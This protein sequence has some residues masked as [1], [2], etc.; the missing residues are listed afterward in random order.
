VKRRPSAFVLLVASFALAIAVS[1]LL[2][3]LSLVAHREIAAA[4]QERN[5]AAEELLEMEKLRAEFALLSTAHR[6]YL[7]SGEQEFVERATIHHATFVQLIKAL[8]PRAGSDDERRLIAEIA[9]QEAVHESAVVQ[10]ISLKSRGDSR[11]VTQEFLEHVLPTRDATQRAIGDLASERS[12]ALGA[13]ERAT[14]SAAART[15]FGFVGLSSLAILGLLLVAAVVIRA[16]WRERRMTEAWTMFLSVASHDLKSPLSALHLR[17]QVLEHLLAKG[18]VDD[19]RWRDELRRMRAQTERMAALVESVLDLT[20]LRLGTVALRPEEVDLSA[21]LTDAVER[22]RPEFDQANIELKL[23]VPGPV[24]GT[25]DPLRLDQVATNL[26]SNALKYGEQRPVEVRIEEADTAVRFAVEDHG[27]G[28][29]V[30]EREH[31]FKP[32]T[33]LKHEHVPG[34]GLGLF[35]ART[36]IE[37]HGGRLRLEDTPG[38]GSTFI[39]ELP[40]RAD[41]VAAAPGR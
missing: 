35:I 12:R 26:L 13:A 5:V 34:H 41:W 22:I 30:E 20:R 1:I 11:A 19:S 21:I 23:T 33:R 40:C 24:L 8:E 6:G 29:S 2:V 18:R 32:F 10:T 14:S 39:V 15:F 25:W 16:H 4:T 28:I 27:N 38:G 36:V 31:L 9:H 17:T 7:L 37:A 3:V